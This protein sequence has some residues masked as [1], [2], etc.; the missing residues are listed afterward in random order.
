MESRLLEMAQLC[1]SEDQRLVAAEGACER[2]LKSAPEQLL[3]KSLH[4]ALVVDPKRAQELDAAARANRGAVEFVRCRVGEA[5]AWMRLSLGLSSGLATAVVVDL[6]ALLA[7]APPLQISRLSSSLSHEIRNPLSSVKMAVQTL[8]RHTGLSER[9][10]RRLAIANREIRTMERML[11]LL[12]EY[13]RD[14]PAMLEP[15]HL[16]A[17]LQ[18]AAAVIEPELSE[19]HIQ[20]QLEAPEGLPKV[21]AEAAR[22][23]PVLAQLLLNVAM[24]QP[25]G[26][27]L[28][29][30]LE[31]AVGAVRLLLKDP[32]ATLPAEERARVFEPF[33]SMLAR[34][35][36]LSLATL[37]RV[38]LA[39]GGEVTAEA[40]SPGTLYTL[41]FRA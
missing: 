1:W 33:G 7:G 27:K 16:R 12:S 6:E 17:L 39:H 36:G 29:A 2:V 32:S 8:A 13:G 3:G 5:S 4:E 25:E 31:P 35:A 9:D 37:H 24:A 14:T 23:R 30:R 38:M 19:R 15:L 10:Q 34:G 26:S 11:W 22:L 20:L 28:Q 40:A 41:T 21:S 18:D